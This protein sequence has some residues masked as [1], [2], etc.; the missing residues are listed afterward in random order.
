MAVIFATKDPGHP[1]NRV[2]AH[3]PTDSRQ[4]VTIECDPALSPVQNCDMAA[5]TLARRIG[6]RGRWTRGDAGSM[7]VYVRSQRDDDDFIN[8]VS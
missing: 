7:Y 4:S 6:W 3:T 5:E 1:F 8:V 2:T